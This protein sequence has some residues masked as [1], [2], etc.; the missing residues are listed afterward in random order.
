[1]MHNSKKY[2]VKVVTWSQ[3]YEEFHR[4]DK[5]PILIRKRRWTLHVILTWR[6]GI[7]TEFCGE[8]LLCRPFERS[9]KWEDG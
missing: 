4:L 5:S 6:Q 1:M 2:N 3:Y 7:F 9:K 8:S